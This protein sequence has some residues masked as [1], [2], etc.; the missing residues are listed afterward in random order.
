M[1]RRGWSIAATFAALSA[2]LLIAVVARGGQEEPFPHERHA[3][4]FP[5]CTGCHE[6]VPTGDTTEFY[7]EPGLCVGCHD[8]VQVDSVPAWTPPP[9]SEPEPI[10]FTHPAH[11]AAT[12]AAG[13]GELDC[14]ACHIAEGGGTMAVQG[15]LVLDQ[16]LAC[17]GHPAE[18]HLVDASCATCHPPAAETRMG[19]E[20]LAGLPYPEDHAL[21]DFLSEIHGELAGAQPQRC[22]TC[23][24]QER[25]VS[26]H[27]DAGDVGEIAAIPA[28][29]PSLDL[30]RFSAHYTAPPS[31][32]AP[33]FLEAHGQEAS[34]AA[35]ATCHTQD[36]CATCHLGDA[37]EAVAALPR[38]TD[39][40]APGVLLSRRAPSSHTSAFFTEE[41]GAMA[42]AEPTACTSCHARTMC[43]D[44]HD[45]AAIDVALPGALAGPGFHPADYM[46]RHSAEA[47]GRRLEC[48]SCHDVAA[49][50]R[51]CHREAGFRAAGRLDPGFHDAEPVWLLRHGD[52]A[53]KALESCATCHEQS[54]CVQCHSTVGS[55]RVSPH[56]RD[57][58]ARRAWDKNPAICFAC[59]LESPIG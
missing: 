9:V 58:D 25:C 37:P 40:M 11:R 16:C 6:G 29:P 30:P 12:V 4:L 1:S 33:D 27:V 15:E 42:A 17:H 47:Y 8:G 46:A 3:G 31:H 7:P 20:W 54:D 19:G 35:C 44:C 26:C 56:G 32:A 43:T 28:A 13:D 2:I 52:P 55:F 5:L 10:E 41:H 21:G 59:H 36:D 49:F 23:H 45:A 39:V 24:T 51:D 53:R 48:S 38:A 57:F 34:V 50:C 22:A 14:A 18:S